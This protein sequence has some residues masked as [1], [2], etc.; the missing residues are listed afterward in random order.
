MPSLDR[1]FDEVD[2]ARSQRAKE[3][4]DLKRIMSSAGGHDPFG[5]RSKAVVVLCYASWEGFYNECITSY[6]K[7]LSEADIKVKEA[8]WFLLVGSLTAEF[9]ALRARN[10]SSESKRLFVEKLKEKLECK[11]EDFDSSVVQSR[12][13]LNFEKLANNF[14]LLDFE[15]GDFSRFRIKI[16]KELVGWRHAVA[17]GNPPD[18]SSLDISRHVDM[19]SDLMLR[20]ADIFQQGMLRRI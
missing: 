11:F 12:S 3:L 8:N 20:T 2:A 5:L 1:Y 4:S 13:N 18:L 7:F 15:I 17:H 10:H 16:D 19:T 9:E 6:V 14:L